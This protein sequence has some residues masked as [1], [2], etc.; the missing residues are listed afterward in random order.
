MADNFIKFHKYS[1]A[2]NDFIIIDNRKQ[3]LV[4]ENLPIKTLCCRKKGIGADGLI[5]VEPS[6]SSLCK[7]RIFNADGSE[8]EMC[9]NGIRCVVDY[10]YSDPLSDILCEIESKHKNHLAWKKNGLITIDMGSPTD[11]VWEIDL[12]LKNDNITASFLNTGVPHT[13]LF[14]E[15]VNSLQVS[16]IGRE[17][18]FHNK[19]TP[20]GTNVNFAQIIDGGIKIRTY[21][22]GVES[23]TEACGTGATAAAIVA[24]KKFK[25][26]PPI[27]VFV[28]SK[29]FLL[30][31]FDIEGNSISNVKM[32]GPCTKVF[33]GR[34][35]L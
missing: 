31:D 34:F 33:E 32:A 1:G 35:K 15:D 8:A 20:K 18:R 3:T 13:V 24:A 23:E 22:R 10:L 2:G 14:C 26:S 19:F 27:K 11:I 4:P 16:S 28:Q 5:L 30:I 17:I 7:M 21:E 6:V 25:I 29:D 12:K 9:G